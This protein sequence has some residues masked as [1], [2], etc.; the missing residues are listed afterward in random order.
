MKQK[1]KKSGEQKNCDKCL[2]AG[3]LPGRREN[4]PSISE[5]KKC[6]TCNGTGIKKSH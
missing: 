5:I 1:Q 4:H 3:T 6:W 2:G